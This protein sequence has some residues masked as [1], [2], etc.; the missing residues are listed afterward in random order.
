LEVLYSFTAGLSF[1]FSLLLFFT[2]KE[3]LKQNIYLSIV[4]LIFSIIL[5]STAADFKP[6]NYEWK[7]N[8]LFIDWLYYIT[9]PF[10]YL[11]LKSISTPKF[12]FTLLNYLH[13]LLPAILLALTLLVYFTLPTEKTAISAWTK[14]P[15]GHFF[16]SIA[17]I[18]FPYMLVYLLA[19]WHLLY[20][21]QKTI[22]QLAADADRRSLSWMR[23]FLA[24]LTILFTFYFFTAVSGYFLNTVIDPIFYL[25]LLVFLGFHALQQPFAYINLENIENNFIDT[26]PEI[27]IS[28]TTEPDKRLEAE[29]DKILLYFEQHKPYLD[30]TLTL[31]KLAGQLGIS[32]HLLSETI[33]TIFK[34]N[35]FQFI[36]RYRIDYATQLLMNKKYAHLTIEAIGYEAGFN[37]KTTFNNTFKKLKGLPPSEYKKKQVAN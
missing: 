31:P 9:C 25:L 30:N 32:H 6:N 24:A 36:N 26:I 19:C 27:S 34:E 17:N 21:H 16:N 28:H 18:L 11:Y 20:K 10:F 29:K 35:F 15:F 12:K 3:K 22:F 23:S 14:R 1:C 37:S 4:F 8:D 2:A 33:N 13:F 7:K 5:L